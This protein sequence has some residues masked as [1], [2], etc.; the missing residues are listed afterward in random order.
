VPVLAVVDDAEDDATDDE[1]EASYG[2]SPLRKR[3]AQELR[4]DDRRRVPKRVGSYQRQD[5]L[6]Q[7][8]IGQSWLSCDRLLAGGI[9]IEVL[10]LRS[11]LLSSGGS[12]AGDERSRLDDSPGRSVDV[13]VALMETILLLHV[14]LRLLVVVVVIIIIASFRL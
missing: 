6:P 11:R 2:L 13:V 7:K 10:R 5:G 4:A 14:A 9:I 12:G 3:F 8:G 1:K